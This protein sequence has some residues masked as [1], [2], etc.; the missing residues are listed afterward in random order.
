V[1]SRLGT[2]AI[3]TLTLSVAIILLALSPV[4]LQTGT[5]LE[6]LPGPLAGVERIGR[7]VASALRPHAEQKEQA[8]G[9]RPQEASQP[10]VVAVEVSAPQAASEGGADVRAERPAREPPPPRAPRR[11][12]PTRPEQQ[13]PSVSAPRPSSGR[14]AEKGEAKAERLTE[15]V[16]AKAERLTEK[17]AAKAERRAEKAA[18]STDRKEEKKDKNDKRHEKEPRSDDGKKPH[19]AHGK[20]DKKHS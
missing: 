14:Q 11:R 5:S 4:V 18:V 20:G 13:P 17:V 2:H 7:V 6:P 8:R 1:G 9:P 10:Q 16:A 15:K 12:R 3:W 19:Q